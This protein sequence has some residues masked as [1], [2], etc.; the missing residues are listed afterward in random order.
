MAGE[1]TTIRQGIETRLETISGLQVYDFEPDGIS[2]TPMCSIRLVNMRRN[3]TFEGA[4]VP[5][6]RIYN[7]MLTL[8]IQGRIPKERW[9]E[10]DSYLAPTGSKSILAAIDG[11]DTLGGAVE[12]TVM[13][14]DEEIEITDQEVRLDSWFYR[15][16]FP[17]ATYK[18]G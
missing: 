1:I 17:L 16:E 5:G 12:W 6:D 7:W 14:P 11:D 8:R 13:T 9:E 2:V 18:S 3:V 15:I 10:V 4:S